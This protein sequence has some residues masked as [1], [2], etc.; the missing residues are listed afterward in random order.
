[1][2]RVPAKIICDVCGQDV[3]GKGAAVD[4]DVAVCEKCKA[5]VRKI[6]EEKDAKEKEQAIE[7]RNP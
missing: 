7:L 4:K 3:A 6:R 2:M 1:M 5:I